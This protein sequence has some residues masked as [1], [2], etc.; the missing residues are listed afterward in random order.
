M[1]R[2]ADFYSFTIHILDDSLFNHT[3]ILC[4]N[5][6]RKDFF[7]PKISTDTMEKVLSDE[8]VE[9]AVSDKHE[10]YYNPLI[11]SLREKAKKGTNR[12][13][14]NSSVISYPT[15]FPVLDYYLG[16][17]VNVYDRF[18]RIIDSYPSIG[19]TCGSF[20]TFIGKPSTSKT[21]TAVQIASNIVRPFESGSVIHFDLEQAMNLTRVKTLSKFKMPEIEAGKYILRQEQNTINDIKATIGDIYV[22]KIQNPDKYKY[23]TGKKDEFGNDIIIFQPTV[24]IIDS[25]AAMSTGINDN[26]KSDLAKLEEVGSQT[27][28][29]RITGEIS[30]FFNEL[31]PIIRTAN[32]I[33]I[34]INQIK[35]KATIGGMP[36]PAD[37]LY[38]RQD[39]S[40]PGGRSPQF[41]AHILCK[42]TAIGGEKYDEEEDGFGGFGVRID[43]IKSRVNQAGRFVNMI[44]DK[45]RGIDP[46]RSTIDWSKEQGLTGGNKNKFYFLTDKDLNFTLPRVHDHFKENRDLYKVM[47][48]NVIPILEAKL[49]QLDDTEMDVIEEE[50]DYSY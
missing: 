8:A 37:I 41:L 11:A 12:F 10:R 44:Y 40:L 35:V 1:N 38:L 5:L 16:Y 31:T 46:L 29:M 49:S 47:Y 19:I 42:F 33:V 27:E 34:C 32:I 24:V 23:N 45:V 48:K 25:I 14:C 21:T 15:G 18:S 7:M 26:S 43:I 30:R 50:Y 2:E 6:H 13:E 36:S 3:Q 22:E 20:V 28:R 39:E 17:R 9:K 4:G